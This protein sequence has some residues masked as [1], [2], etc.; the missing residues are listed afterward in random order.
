MWQLVGNYQVTGAATVQVNVPDSD[1]DGVNDDSDKCVASA[2]P[3]P[4]GCPL[5]PPTF[6]V[7][8]DAF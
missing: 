3:P 5:T 6:V 1:R 2:G 8:R 7:E 4:D